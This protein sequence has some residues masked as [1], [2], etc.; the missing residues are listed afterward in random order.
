MMSFVE[1]IKIQLEMLAQPDL[2]RCLKSYI[3]FMMPI[4]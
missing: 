1:K 2:Q 3:F 4:P